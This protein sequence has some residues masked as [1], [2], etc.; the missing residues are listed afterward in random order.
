MRKVAA[1]A[2]AACPFLSPA[3]QNLRQ[4]D[5]LRIKRQVYSLAKARR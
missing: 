3:A 2:R 5:A 4:R 1:S